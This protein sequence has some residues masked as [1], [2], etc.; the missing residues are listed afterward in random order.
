M[1]A[2][3]HLVRRLDLAE[4]GLTGTA[5]A[6]LICVSIIPALI[7]LG[8][9]FYLLFLYPYDRNCCCRRRKTKSS[10]SDMVQ[11]PDSNP[12]DLWNKSSYTIP[13]GPT[14]TST[15]LPKPGMGGSTELGNGG[16]L[17]KSRTATAQ[18]PDTRESSQSVQSSNT[19]QVLQEPKRFV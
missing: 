19:V 10:Q 14:S 16:R 7:L 17:T 4:G 12:G 5:W 13:Q 8:S 6:I 18:V 9:T 1:P 3:H 2:L 11:P 15:T